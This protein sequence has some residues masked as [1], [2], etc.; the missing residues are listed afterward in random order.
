MEEME[1]LQREAWACYPDNYKELSHQEKID[2][3]AEVNFKNPQL[4][5]L[6]S[7]YFYLKGKLER[8]SLNYRIQGNAATMSKIAG[9]LIHNYYD[10]NRF[11]IN[12]VHDEIIGKTISKDEEF[13]NIVKESMIKAGTYTCK[14]VK[15]DAEAELAN[16]WKH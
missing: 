1:S 16:Y 10:G 8:R 11:I 9:C 7:K 2:V 15:M 4:K 6:W 14:R 3:K 13:L 12:L 5:Q